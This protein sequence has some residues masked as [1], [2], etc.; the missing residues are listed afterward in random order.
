[1][2][3]L[4]QYVLSVICTAILCG[5]VLIIFS[6]NVLLSGPI[7]FA[8]GLVMSIVVISPILKMNGLPLNELLSDI[9]DFEES[10]A[11][12][13]K[14]QT[15][16]AM[17]TIILEKTQTYILQQAEMLGANVTVEVGLSADAVPVP[18]TVTIKGAVSPH[19]RTQLARMIVR[20]L[21]IAEENQIWI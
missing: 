5:I 17:E 9:P 16:A 10:Y 14:E 1:M 3:G 20:D 6:K 18:E 13:G 15:S 2:E 7:K 12:E 4:S 19:T 8:V 21:N 11:I